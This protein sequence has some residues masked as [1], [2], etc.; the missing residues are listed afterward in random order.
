MTNRLLGFAR[1]Q[2]L[3]TASEDL[4]TLLGALKVFLRLRRRARHSKSF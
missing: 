3:E 4:N 2:Q 1:Q